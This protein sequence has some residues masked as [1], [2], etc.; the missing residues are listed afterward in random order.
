MTSITYSDVSDIGFAA[1]ATLV[2]AR[3]LGLAG[4]ITLVIGGVLAGVP[5]MNDPVLQQP[6]LKAVRE[7]VTPSVLVVSVGLCLLMLAWWRLGRLVRSGNG[8]TIRELVITFAWWGTPLL[9]T[10]PIFSRDVYSYLA[11]GTMTVLGVDAYHYGPAVFGGP[12]A[13]DIPQIWQTTPAP[14]GPVFLSLAADVTSI[15]G[16]STW[17][18]VIGMRVLAL[19]GLALM[20]FAVPRLARQAGVDERFALWLGV[21]NPLVLVHLVG[22]AHNDALMIGLMM[23]GLTL[24]LERRPAAGA[25][26]VT[27]A[28]LV[29]APAGLALVFIVPLWAAQLSGRA[30]LLRT[31]L[32][33]GGIALATVFVTTELAG[34]GYG[35]IGALDTPTLAHTWTSITTDLGYWTGVA[36][37]HYRLA[38]ADQALAWVRLAGL[39]VAGTICLLMLRKHWTNPATGVGLGLA[40]VLALGPVVHPWYLLWAIVPL[41]ASATSPRVRRWVIFFSLAMTALAFPGGVQPNFASGLGMA[42][43]AVLVF[44]TAWVISNVDRADPIRSFVA[45]LRRVASRRPAVGR[46]ATAGEVLERE[47]VAV[48]AQAADNPDGDR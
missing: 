17:F 6:A 45:A 16:E 7:F 26:L 21:L 9:V 15:T 27:A 31:G 3:R 48:H 46:F 20:I 22:D 42:L 28:A 40:A 14:Y 35:W 23:A 13:V 10:M 18:G 37:E 25:V 41:A 24:A 32:A 2:R 39:A 4:A 11:Q 43:G 33:T 44:G 5:P 29:K 38:T 47:P 12:L 8:P 34:T 19:V 30:R 1:D 36:A